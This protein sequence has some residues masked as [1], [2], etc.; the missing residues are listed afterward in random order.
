MFCKNG[1]FRNFA[2]FTGTHLCQSL[3][4]NKIASLRHRFFPVNF[5]KFLRAGLHE[6]RSELK[7]VWNFKPLWK[8]VLFTW[9]FHY[10]QPWNLK[11]LSKIVLL[12]WIF[13]C[14]N[15]PNHSKA[16]LHMLMCVL[17]GSALGLFHHCVVCKNCCTIHHHVSNEPKKMRMQP[18]KTQDK[19]KP[20]GKTVDK[21][22]SSN[23]IVF[24]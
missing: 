21:I 8:V 13:H 5:M 3:F 22:R 16:L 12:T 20:Q 9:Q 14:G 19:E 18:P 11:L 6:T 7:P 1:V 17:Y 4:F 24:E 15:F 10:G 2:K 23:R